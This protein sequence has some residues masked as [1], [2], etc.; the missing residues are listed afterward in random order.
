MAQGE[1]LICATDALA[2]GGLG[3]RFEV[4]RHGE[5]LPAFVIRHGGRVY[6]YVNEC[7]HQASELD[8]NPGEFFDVDKLYLICATHGA[9]YEPK[10]GLCV[11]GP[12]R[13][14]SLAPVPV[15]ERDGNVFCSED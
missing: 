8:W 4:H 1:R 12:C 15:H 13:G 10:N 9:L 14:A 6:A 5:S 3:V 7:R 2:D 11:A